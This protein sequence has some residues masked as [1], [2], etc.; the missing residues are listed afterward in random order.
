MDLVEQGDGFAAFWQERH[1]CTLSTARPGG[2]PHVVPVGVTLDLRA[3]VARVITSGGS[4]KARLVGAAG[5]EGAPVSL[6][7][8]DGR[9]WSTLE[10]RAV[11]RTGAEEVADA[12]RRYAARY[13]P[14]RPNPARV[15]VEIRVTRVLGNV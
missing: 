6:C 2:P 8:V 12:E 9:R 10:G 5:E 11:L 13:K 15:V 14:P 3:G 1:L 7:Q 4:V